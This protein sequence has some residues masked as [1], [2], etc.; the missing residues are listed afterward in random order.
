MNALS[1]SLAAALTLL[2]FAHGA[3]A[4]TADEVVAKSIAALGG[5]AAFAKLKSRAAAGTIT[6]QTPH[7]PS[8]GTIEVWSVAPNKSRSL[9]KV[10]VD[11]PYG[12]RQVVLD[13]RFDGSAGYA[14]DT[15][16]GNHDITGEQ[17]ENMR[18]DTFPHAYL[19]Y[20]ERGIAV[21]L[22]GKEKVGDRDA[23]V[24]VFE[25]PAGSA[26]RAY[27]DAATYLPIKTVIKVNVP[28]L[29]QDVE[30]T[31]DLSDYRPVDGV[32]LPFRIGV[33][34]SVQNY[35]IVVEKVEHNVPIDAT[36]FSKP[37]QPQP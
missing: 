24:V 5:R 2:T 1:R 18:N 27:I 23:F 20:K 32:K 10:E 16:Q 11:T 12:R 13:Q 36:M 15:L 37:A 3:S 25:P 22:A 19:T 4:Q 17:L 6:L 21:Q 34:S 35:S 28:Q 29:D 9:I 30:M 26:V 33:R 14:I 8:P 31:S 7:G